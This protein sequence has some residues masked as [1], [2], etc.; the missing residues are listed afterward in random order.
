M[1]LYID[2]LAINQ[3]YAISPAKAMGQNVYSEDFKEPISVS[4]QLN[5][6]NM[7]NAN[8]F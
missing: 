3:I 5:Y 8:Q 4:G 7:N 1:E 6:Q 2:N